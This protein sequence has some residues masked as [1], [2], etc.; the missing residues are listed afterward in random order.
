[1][2]GVSRQ[3]KYDSKK[4][5]YLKNQKHKVFCTPAHNADWHTLYSNGR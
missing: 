2:T 5:I 3:I 1:V 4:S